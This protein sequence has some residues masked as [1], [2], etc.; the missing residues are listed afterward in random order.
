LSEV[1]EIDFFCSL[2]LTC[3]ST[4]LVPHLNQEVY[5]EGDL[6]VLV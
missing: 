3:L 5:L 6:R 2:I 1:V 4:F